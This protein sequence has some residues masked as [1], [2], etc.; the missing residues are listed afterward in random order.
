MA[1]KTLDMERIRKMK[2]RLLSA[3]LCVCVG[4]FCSLGCEK[5]SKE[6]TSL[7]DTVKTVEK[8]ADDAATAAEKAV[9]DAKD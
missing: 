5:K 4:L 7:S 2:K 9:D 3:I 1:V 6:E 8:A